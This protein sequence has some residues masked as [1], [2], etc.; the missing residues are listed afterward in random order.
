MIPAQCG[1][2]WM[3]GQRSR[4]PTLGLKYVCHANKFLSDFSC[5]VY[6]SDWQRVKL[7]LGCSPFEMRHTGELMAQLVEDVSESWNIRSKV[8]VSLSMV[9]EI[10][11]LLSN[12]NSMVPHL[13]YKVAGLC[14]DT[15]SNMTS[16]MTFLPNLVWN[17]C[18]NH[19]IQLVV[20][21]SEIMLPFLI[22]IFRM[23]SCRIRRF[24]AC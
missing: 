23:T 17:G 9:P 18:L 13:I 16:M 12:R 4:H 10:C 21:V 14:T 19:I 1:S 2:S 6:I 11:V 3:D 20:N 8:C 24:P 7:V 15:A 22:N 5:L